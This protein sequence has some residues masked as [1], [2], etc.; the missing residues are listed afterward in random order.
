MRRATCANSLPACLTTKAI[1]PDSE[2]TSW[3]RSSS[4]F[5][6]FVFASGLKSAAPRHGVFAAWFRLWRPPGFLEAQRAFDASSAIFF[7][8]N[9]GSTP[10]S[11]NS[12]SIRREFR[13]N[14][15][16]EG[17][18]KP[19]GSTGGG[20]EPYCGFQSRGEWQ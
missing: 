9:I 1:Q 3:R 5:F 11:P 18:L 7:A 19:R 12:V 2:W 13:R 16:D 6:F 14:H 8:R 20:G 17:Q 4:V 10:G 15:I